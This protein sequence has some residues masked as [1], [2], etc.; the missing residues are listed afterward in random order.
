MLR[1]HASVDPPELELPLLWELCE[2]C[3][4]CELP[5]LPELSELSELALS[6]LSPVCELP[7]EDE[8]CRELDSEVCSVPVWDVEPDVE[9]EP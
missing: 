2:L 1:P 9:P 5:E 7:R 8:P 3:E 4:P 6:E